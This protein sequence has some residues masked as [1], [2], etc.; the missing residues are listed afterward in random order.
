M[1]NRRTTTSYWVTRLSATAVAGALAVVSYALFVPRA[2]NGASAYTL[3]PTT[4]G[5]EVRTPDNR[6]IFEYLTKKPENVG[7]TSTSAACFHPV[8]TPSG[9]RITAL[10]PNDHPHHRGIFLGW[11]A[12]EFREPADLSTYGPHAPHRATNIN[13]ADFWGWG[14]FAPREGR[15]IQ[16]RDVKLVRADAD[17]LEMEI[18]NDWMVGR[19]KRLDEVTIAKVAERSGV[20][21]IDFEFRL[22]P[23]VDYVLDRAAF[24]GFTV[25]ARKDGESY[26]ANAA[27]KVDLPDPHYSMPDLNWP[28]APWYDYSI[29]LQ[30]SGKTLG[31]AVVDDP[32][33]PTTTWHNSTH[34]WMVHPTI[35][36]GG[37]ITIQHGATLTLR[38]LVVVHD[39]DTPTAVLQKLSTEWRGGR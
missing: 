12:S 38:Y 22:T 31:V 16:N 28:S 6:V 34:L 39:G 30:G 3:T 24:G 18:H 5:M 21:T 17:H 37:P 8:N 4:Y 9:K 7:L 19:Q 25:Q 32:R 13:R 29:K 15:M 33:N 1:S 36:A 20:Y 10:A 35:V 23:L 26:F 2:A 11:Q 14:E 27:G